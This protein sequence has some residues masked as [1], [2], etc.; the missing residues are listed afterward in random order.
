MNL[1]NNLVIILKIL[2]GIISLEAKFFEHP[3]S[4]YDLEYHSL[5]IC[6]LKVDLNKSKQIDINGKQ[7]RG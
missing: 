4:Y 1:R 2:Q 7:T 5:E 3:D 6:Y